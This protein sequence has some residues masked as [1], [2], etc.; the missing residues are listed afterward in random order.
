ML[1]KNINKQTKITFVKYI[2]ILFCYKINCYCLGS[3]ETP[4][5]MSVDTNEDNQRVKCIQRTLTTK[6]NLQN[7]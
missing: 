6:F 7:K 5:I 2:Y 4:K 1:S 3:L